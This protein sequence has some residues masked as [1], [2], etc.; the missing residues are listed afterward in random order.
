M[1]SI[2]GIAIPPESRVKMDG[3]FSWERFDGLHP[4]EFLTSHLPIKTSSK[5]SSL[6][7]NIMGISGTAQP[8]HTSC[9]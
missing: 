1:T 7:N 3:E 8:P 2:S 4:Y 5:N 6:Q 9:M